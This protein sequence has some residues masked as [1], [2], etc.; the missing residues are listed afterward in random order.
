MVFDRF[1]RADPSRSRSTG[2]SGLG[3]AIVASI[4]HAHGGSVSV[5]PS[6]DGGAMFQVRLPL[7]RDSAGAW[8]APTPVDRPEHGEGC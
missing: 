4:V 2:G 5:H 3:L 7:L 8:P 6:P 1:F